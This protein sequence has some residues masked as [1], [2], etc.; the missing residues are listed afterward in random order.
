[1]FDTPKAHA[2]IR[3]QYNPHDSV[4]ACTLLSQDPFPV[5]SSKAVLTHVGEAQRVQ[6]DGRRLDLWKA[7]HD[8]K[9]VVL[10]KIALL[11]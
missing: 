10:N 7:V 1:M 9:A 5:S 2:R 11:V 3:S 6:N 4:I 8:S